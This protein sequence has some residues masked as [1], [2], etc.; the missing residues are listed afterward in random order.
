MNILFLMKAFEVGGQEVVTSTL[1]QSFVSHGH[2]VTIVSFKQPNP[3]MQ[4][5][6]NRR[7]EVLTLGKFC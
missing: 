7:I 2:S 5:R 1:A 4:K 6:L 3:L